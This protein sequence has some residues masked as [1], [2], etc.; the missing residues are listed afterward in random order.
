M[1]T[2]FDADVDIT[3]RV[4][5]SQGFS[6]PLNRSQIVQETLK[7]YPL[8]LSS[9][10]I[11]DAFQ[12]SLTTAA[13][14]DL[15]LTAGA[16]ATGVPY[17]TSGDVKATSGTRYARTTFVLP[18]EYDAGQSITLRFAAGMLTTVS[19]T[20]CTV[21]AEAYLSARDT[22]KSGSD[23][24]STAATSINSLTFGNKDFT[25]TATG[26]TAGDTLDIRIAIIWV[27]AATATAVIGAISNAE[28]LLSIRG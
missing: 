9:F 12:T 1:A 28:V 23:L 22:L 19:D 21:D 14:D 3:G 15:G 17:I 24:V 16:F 2:R 6:G 5:A 4:T 13:S 25:I 18:P 11:W 8:E 20:S 7:A 27:D 26:R 10:R